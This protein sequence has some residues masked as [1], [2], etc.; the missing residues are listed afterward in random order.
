MTSLGCH[1]V[2]VLTTTV[3]Y[4]LVAMVTELCCHLAYDLR[5]A[6]HTL[7]AMLLSNYK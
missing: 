6:W 1:S 3:G 7:Y 4:S 2:M 5:E